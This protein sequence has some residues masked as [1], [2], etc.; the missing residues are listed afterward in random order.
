MSCVATKLWYLALR[1]INGYYL[2]VLIL[3]RDFFS[4]R[5]ITVVRYYKLL[6]KP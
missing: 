1:G 6:Y 2:C 4:V 3:N 5:I